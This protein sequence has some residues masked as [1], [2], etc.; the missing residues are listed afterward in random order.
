MHSPHHVIPYTP[1]IRPRPLPIPAPQWPEPAHL[2]PQVDW[3][4][5]HPLDPGP[6]QTP[7][8]TTTT[9]IVCADTKPD[10]LRRLQPLF[11]IVTL[12]LAVIEGCI[13]AFLVSRNNS[14]DWWVGSSL[15]GR[16]RFLLFTS[17]W[18]VVLNSIYLAFFFVSGPWFSSVLSHIIYVGFTWLL[19]LSGAASFT[20]SIGGGR[21]CAGASS[22]PH[23]SLNIAAEALA[24][25]EFI[26]FS[27]FLTMMGFVAGTMARRGDRLSASE[28]MV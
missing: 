10:R 12:L 26:I 28:G 22:M 17:W 2:A 25:V 14:D 21:H 9:V 1:L 23:C 4:R 5:P 13:T 3:A 18:T 7:A 20:R 6:L 11:L 27:I 19:W 16:T 24:W 8:K 15:H